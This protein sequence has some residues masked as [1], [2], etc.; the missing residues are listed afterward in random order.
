MSRDAFATETGVSRET[1]A[2]LSTYLDLLCRWQ[3]AI[4]LVGRATLSD[5]W[6]RHFLD[7]AQLAPQLPAGAQNLVDLGSG[8][9]FP[10]MVLALLGLRD[11]HLIE[12][13]RRKAEFLREVT[14][15]TGAPVTVHAQRIERLAG[16]PADV[17]TGR[18]VAPLPRLLGLAEPFLKPESVCLFLKGASVNRELTEARETWH[19]YLEAIP[20]RSALSGTVLKLR[21]VH[22]ARD[23]QP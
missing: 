12:A 6:R 22:R 20:S 5:P 1:L 7:S 9:G 17:I 10:G 19:M 3:A 4:N 11:V 16:W 18:A 21:G 8:A 14:R 2:R 15:A 13:D 23:R